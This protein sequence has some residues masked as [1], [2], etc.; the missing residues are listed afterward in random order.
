MSAQ[1]HHSNPEEERLMRR[2]LDEA[3][4]TANRQWPHGRIS[5][6]DDG[7][8]AF[9]IATDPQ[10]KIVRIQF[11]KPMNWLGLDKDSALKLAAMLTEKAGEL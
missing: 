2:F 6:E 8:T 3:A 10:N 4:G 5:G 11:T 1:H 9:A 7:E